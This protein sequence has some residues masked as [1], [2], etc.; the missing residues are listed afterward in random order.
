MHPAM[1]VG[2]TNSGFAIL[3][4]Y[5]MPLAS[6]PPP[7]LTP[8]FSHMTLGFSMLG[9]AE[10]VEEKIMELQERKIKMMGSIIESSDAASLQGKG[11]RMTEADW[12][13]LL[14]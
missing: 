1:F 10:T 12:N 7:S 13:A 8:P 11:N 5:L 6:P 2:Q 3:P 9:P 14:S 4:V